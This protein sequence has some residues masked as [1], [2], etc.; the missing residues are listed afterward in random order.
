MPSSTAAR[1]A[2]IAS[3]TRHRGSAEVAALEGRIL[4]NLLGGADRS[5]RRNG[6]D[7]N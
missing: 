1:V 3:S 5:R 7:Q 2:C 6:T 4:E